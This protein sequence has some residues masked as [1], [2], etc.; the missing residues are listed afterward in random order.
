MEHRFVVIG[1]S[2]KGRILVVA[3]SERCDNIRIIS[4]RI[5]TNKERKV[6]EE[7]KYLFAK[8]KTSSSSEETTISSIYFDFFASSIAYAI[9]GFPQTIFPGCIVQVCILVNN[10]LPVG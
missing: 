7:G 2:V 8:D 5:A 1:R 6:Y 10:R 3:H 4:A 9:I